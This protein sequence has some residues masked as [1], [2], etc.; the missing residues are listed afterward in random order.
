MKHQW[1]ASIFQ[2]IAPII[3]LLSILLRKRFLTLRNVQLN[4]T[5]KLRSTSRCSQCGGK[6]L[7]IGVL[8]KGNHYQGSGFHRKKRRKPLARISP[9]RNQV[10]FLIGKERLFPKMNDGNQRISPG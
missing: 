4:R 2:I 3:A 8:V 1:E 7:E 9:L 10:T 5:K 6:I